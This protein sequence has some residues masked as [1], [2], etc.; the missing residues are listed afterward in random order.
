MSHPSADASTRRKRLEE[1]LEGR[2]DALL[3]IDRASRQIRAADRRGAFGYTA[4]ELLALRLD[5]LLRAGDTGRLEEAWRK[6]TAASSPSHLDMICWTKERAEIPVEIELVATDETEDGDVLA[7]VRD[8]SRQPSAEREARRA[9]A[10]LDAVIESLPDMIFVKDAETARFERFNRAG[11]EFLGIPRGELLGKSLSELAPRPALDALG[12]EDLET[13]R[14]RGRVDIPE[15]EIE[16]RQGPRWVRTRKVPILDEKGVAKYVLG[17]LEDI[18]DRKLAEERAHVLESELASLLRYAHDAVITWDAD[19]RVVLWNPAAESFYGI[20]AQ[21][22][23]GSP[24]ESLLPEK[25]RFPF[26]AALA[27]LLSGEQTLVTGVQRLRNGREIE[28]SLF[29]LPASSD[30]PVRV[31]SIARDLSEIARLRRVNE[32]LA[33]P[34]EIP[35]RGVPSSAMK[36][37]LESAEIAA[38]DPYATVLILG[39][40]GVGKGWLARQIHAKSPRARKPFFELNCAGLGRELLESELFGHLRGAF[41]SAVTHKQG[42]VEVAEGGT[43]FLDEVGAISS[44]VQSKLLG[45]L[46]DRTFRA[47]GGIRNVTADVRILAATNVDL[48]Q[49]ADK[50]EFRRDLYFRLNVVP[51]RV[52]PLR[53]RRDEISELAATIVE[54]LG[55]RGGRPEVAFGQGVIEALQR[56]DWPGNVRELKNALERALILGRGRTIEIG[57]L[58][59]EFQQ[60]QAPRSPALRLRNAEKAHI[61]RVLAQTHGN[62]SR[63]A[64][65][66]GISR[67]TLKRKL[68]EWRIA[69]S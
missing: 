55:K 69:G 50:G 60:A 16:T 61:L 1:F 56:Y 33:G 68:R 52:P 62:R 28:E 20:S 9:N 63:T 45:F 46:D 13:I 37:V 42:L 48:K 38:R 64:K 22:A 2:P 57:H 67:S 23:V 26:R 39:E 31:A 51:I 29:L 18:T 34:A 4:A 53:E 11:E 40:T 58:P 3:L 41:T 24:I 7:T 12:G 10:L 32:I 65:T 21:Q 59:S 43:L 17:I 6:L 49:A 44:E 66:L 8:S 5:E 36:E 19:G 47:V 14:R 15:Q 25:A 30:R 27:R 54:E 35:P